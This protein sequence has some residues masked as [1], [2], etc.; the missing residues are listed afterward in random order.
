MSLTLLHSEQPKLCR[1]LAVLSAKSFG[2]S[3]CKK[4]KFTFSSPVQTYRKSYCT[5]QGVCVGSGIGS[6]FSK[7]LMF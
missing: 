2:C 7:M 4:V 1:V 5:I 3:E 6:G